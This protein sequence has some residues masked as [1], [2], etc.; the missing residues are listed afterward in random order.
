MLFSLCYCGKN[1]LLRARGRNAHYNTL[2]GHNHTFHISAK[3]V[4]T[5]ERQ[6]MQN[7]LMQLIVV[8]EKISINRFET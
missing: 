3:Y 5:Y 8:I 2:I 6:I 4:I 7:R 1:L